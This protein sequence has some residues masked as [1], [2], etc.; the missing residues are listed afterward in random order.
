M[1]DAPAVSGL[2]CPN[3]GGVLSVDPGL[4]VAACPYCSTS[5]LVVG[6]VGV[7][8]F[9]VEPSVEADKA[10]DAARAW[11]AK[12]WNKDRRLPAEAEIGEAFLCFLP[13]FRAEADVV[14]YAFGTE[15]RQRS[16]GSGNN[17]RTETY[18]VDVERSVAR[19]F[20]QTFPAIN[21]A[22]WGVQKV[23]LAGDRLV[24]YDEPALSRLGMVFPP[25][26]S[27]AEVREAAGEEL[28]RQGDPT[29]GLKRVHFRW[30][31]SLRRRFGVIHYPLWV[32]R[33]RFR[34]RSYQVLV[35]A[36]D[37]SIAYA[38]APGNDLYRSTMLVASEAGACFVGSTALQLLFHSSDGGGAFA[39]LFFVALVC[40]AI[41]AWGWKRFR[42]GGEVVE[43]SGLVDDDSAFDLSKAS[44]MVSRFVPG[45]RG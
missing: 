31:A 13:F 30:V 11:L 43:G 41:V 34:Q 39:F 8:R 3:C 14:G 29:R 44:A 18:E 1:S 2:A 12:G 38:K 40:A 35:D 22:E 28:E 23:N 27:E 7:R 9:A 5:L 36:D 4:R 15:E 20:D 25:T 37:A 33:Y 45:R 32:V 24:P 26:G 19:H 17:R 6:E 42:Y 10:R 16:V 21:V